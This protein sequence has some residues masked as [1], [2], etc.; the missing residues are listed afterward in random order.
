MMPTAEESLPTVDDDNGDVVVMGATFS[1]EEGSLS[2]DEG[3]TLSN[4]IFLQ[5]QG[6]GVSVLTGTT[7]HLADPSTVSPDH[8]NPDRKKKRRKRKQTIL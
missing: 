7:H 5:S 3:D 4:I 2:S 1:P 6:G 8:V